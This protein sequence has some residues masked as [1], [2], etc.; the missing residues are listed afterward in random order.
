MGCLV[1]DDDSD[2]DDDGGNDEQTTRANLL[3]S[4]CVIPVHLY[5]NTHISHAGDVLD[6]Q[7]KIY[8]A[9]LLI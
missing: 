2:N 1:V 6:T 3:P 9:Q 8:R 5:I 4:G 7:G